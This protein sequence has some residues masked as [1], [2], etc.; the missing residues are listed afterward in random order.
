[1]FSCPRLFQFSD[2]IHYT[3]K[4]IFHTDTETKFLCSDHMLLQHWLNKSMFIT[5]K[6]TFPVHQYR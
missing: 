2:M 1:M 5:N 3:F 6:S 4:S